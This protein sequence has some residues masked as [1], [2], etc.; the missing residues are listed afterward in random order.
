MRGVTGAFRKG[1][2]GVGAK[3]VGAVGVSGSAVFKVGNFSGRFFQNG[4]LY[5]TQ[6][7]RRA[8]NPDG[9]ADR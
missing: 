7:K 2:F 3:G 9:G 5:F 1:C 6:Q 8:G 4:V